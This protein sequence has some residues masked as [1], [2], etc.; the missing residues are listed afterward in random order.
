[1]RRKYIR[2]HSGAASWSPRFGL[3]AAALLLVSLA[4]HRLGFIATL[5]LPYFLALSAVLALIALFL[6]FLGLRA[7]WT[8]GAAGGLASVK[9]IIFA[10]IALAPLLCAAAA[11]FVFPPLYE[12]STDFSNPPAFLPQMRPADALRPR[13]DFSAAA[14]AEQL[15][16]WPH[17][18]G[19]RYD[20]S[21]DAVL[22]AVY[23]VLQA[24]HWPVS[25]A[26]GQ[27]GE[28]RYIFVGAVAKTLI[29]GF[30][31]DIIIRVTDE[32]D[33]SFVDMRAAARYLRRDFGINAR[34]AEAFFD[35]LD[36]QML[37]LPSDENA[38]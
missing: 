3:L 37:A 19:R 2:P 18:T 23:A 11:W 34:F 16:A 26:A 38:D 32:G 1:M 25:A 21:P 35:R 30:V 13:A 27:P 36:S 12:I 15:N 7:L 5:N 4:L 24:N 9:G 10:A 6:A 17:L 33:T 8:D 22:K 14:A 20:G 31:S 28:D 29:M